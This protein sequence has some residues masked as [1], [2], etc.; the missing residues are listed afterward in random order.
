MARRLLPIVAVAMLAALPASALAAGARYA[1]PTASGSGDCSTAANACTLS[2]AFG[3]ASA[4]DDVFVLGDR[5]DYSL[6]SSLV[7]APKVQVHG[8]NGRPRILIAGAFSFRLAGAQSTAE[9]LYVESNGSNTTFALDGAGSKANDVIARNTS[10]HACY[11]QDSTLTNSVCLATTAGTGG[12]AELDGSNTLR[13]VTVLAP[14]TGGRGIVAFGRSP[15]AGTVTDTFV[16]VIARG[17]SPG[18][19][20]FAESDDNV[21]VT[22]N[23]TYSNFDSTAAL[24][25]NGSGTPT[26]NTDAT[27]Q[28]TAPLLV[29]VAAGDF[30]QAPGSPTIDQGINSPANG[31]NDFDGDP[32]TFGART[33]IGADEFRPAPTAVTGQATNVG[34]T[35]ATP[36]GSVNPN[37][38]PT[39]Y[40]FVYGKT[41]SY[42]SSTA[43]KSAGGGL[44]ALGVSASLTGLAPATTY[45][46]KLLA[47]SVAGSA[48]GAD[49]T[50]TTRPAEKNPFA[51]PGKKKCLDRRK[52]TFKPKHRPNGHLVDIKVLINGKLKVHRTGANL[53]K[54]TIKKLPKKKFKVTI[55]GTQDNGDV[56]T[57]TRTYR[58]CKKSKPKTHV[59]HHH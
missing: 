40:R 8:I 1:A 18:N 17:G 36:T 4:G 57:S 22:V 23:V 50:F 49:R 37:S 3:G 15:S 24:T 52:F 25:G 27:D 59:H 29:D 16:N 10:G 46:Y 45:H 56:V 47:S 58:G 28:T 2:T 39:A 30:H 6:G 7:V 19:G 35:I 53:T 32:R 48:Q 33:D 21:N 54:V 26:V 38:S 12:S 5:G 20:I 11:M 31:T 41:T 13:N 44:A 43:S 42:G 14:G 34:L 51:L 9:H 55:V